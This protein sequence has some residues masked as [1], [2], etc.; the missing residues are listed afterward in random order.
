MDIRFNVDDL[1]L[2]QAE[3]LCEYTGRTVASVAEAFTSGNRT[4]RDLIAVLALTLNPD[5]PQAALPEVR[6][7]RVADRSVAAE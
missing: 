4:I 3:F 6:A 7:P 2:G 1:T 5:N